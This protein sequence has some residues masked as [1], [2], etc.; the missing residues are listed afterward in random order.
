M[1]VEPTRAAVGNGNAVRAE[2]GRNAGP[3]SLGQI[4]PVWKARGITLDVV[5]RESAQQF[6]NRDP[7]RLALD[8]PQRQVQRA[9]SVE[10]FASRRVKISAEHG[11]PKMVDPRRILADQHTGALLHRIPAA[12]FADPGDAGVGFHGDDLVTLVEGRIQVTRP[13]N[14]DPGDLHPR[15]RR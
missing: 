12:A 5:A 14:P 9:E 13:V 15:E 1:R 11:L 3:G 2:S 8:V 10:L 6:V 4:R 7:E